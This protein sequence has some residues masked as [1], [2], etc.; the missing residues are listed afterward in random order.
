MLYTKKSLNG[1]RAYLICKDSI[2]LMLVV[3]IRWKLCNYPSSL[4]FCR[5]K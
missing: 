5:Y 4:Y 2:Y 3:I 1:M